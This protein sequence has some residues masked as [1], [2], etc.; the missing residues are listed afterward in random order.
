MADYDNE[1]WVG[2]YRSAMVELEHAKVAE[3]IGNARKEISARIEE[4][5][6]IPG[7]HAAEKQAI[8]GALSDLQRLER[9]EE[10]YA[11]DERRTAKAMKARAS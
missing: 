1:N 4:L 5:Q 8:D 6:G 3:R 10:R 7:P 2:L 9:M 11:Q